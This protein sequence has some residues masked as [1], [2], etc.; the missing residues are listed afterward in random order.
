M[1]HAL[2]QPYN[3]CMLCFPAKPEWIKEPQKVDAG[4][5]ESAV[6]ECSAEGRP[7]PQIQWFINGKSLQSMCFSFQV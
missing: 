1:F 6:F 2:R 7:P 4:V 3:H 5:E